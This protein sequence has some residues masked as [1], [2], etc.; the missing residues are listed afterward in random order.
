MW[1][2]YQILTNLIII[3]NKIKKNFQFGI[4]IYNVKE[5]GQSCAKKNTNWNGKK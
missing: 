2:K 5:L 3:K 1:A 4:K